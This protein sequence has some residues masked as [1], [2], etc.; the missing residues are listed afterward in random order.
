MTR[1]RFIDNM[2][3][4]ARRLKMSWTGARVM[5]TQRTGHLEQADHLG[6]TSCTDRIGFA[7]RAAT[8]ANAALVLPLALANCAAPSHYMG[9]DLTAPPAADQSAKSMSIHPLSA[10]P[11]A[12]LSRSMPAPNNMA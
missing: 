2:S 9:I 8:R 12:A 7:M 5:H 11:R 3:G 10:N 6:R 4:K 1:D